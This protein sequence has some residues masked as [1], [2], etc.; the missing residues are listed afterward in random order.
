VAVSESRNPQKGLT[1]NV[2]KHGLG[3]IA[4]QALWRD[5]D[6]LQI[7][8]RSLDEPRAQVIGQ[9]ADVLWSA[10]ITMWDDR[11]RI[12]SVRRAWSKSAMCR[13]R[14][15]DTASIQPQQRQTSIAS[16]GVIDATP[17]FTL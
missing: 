9:I 4:A 14:C 11:I 3:F 17:E 16:F 8:A 2:E 1:A 12:I 5:P 15:T 6:R 10:F 7:P 13:M